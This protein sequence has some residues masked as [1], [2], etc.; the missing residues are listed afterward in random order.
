MLEIDSYFKP[1]NTKTSEIENILSSNP[2][3]YLDKNVQMVFGLLQDKPNELSDK[4]WKELKEQFKQ[5]FSDLLKENKIILGEREEFFN[6]D[7]REQITIAV[8]HHTST[9]ANVDANYINAINLINLYY[10][11]YKSGFGKINNEFQPISSGHFYNNKQ[12]F[13]GYHYLVFEDGKTLQVL[14]DSYVGFHA[15]DYKTNC[16]SI[17]IAVV[18]DLENIS[19]TEKAISSIKDIIRKYTTIQ[20]V[21]GHK[22]VIY[23]EKQVDTLCP[24]NKWDDWKSGLL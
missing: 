16:K 20:K 23:N 17:G 7:D 4:N 5:W 9:K 13:I 12:T 1:L 14:K 21:I 24:G 2:L 6:D 8:I 10:P 18:D 11:I 19:P 15:G 3:W 22:E